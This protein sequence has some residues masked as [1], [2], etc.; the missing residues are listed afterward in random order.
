MCFLKEY[1][2]TYQRLSQTEHTDPYSVHEYLSGA[3]GE[4]VTVKLGASEDFIPTVMTDSIRYLLNV[5]KI[6][7]AELGLEWNMDE[8]MKRLGA[9][10]DLHEVDI[11]LQ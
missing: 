4:K 11:E 10:Q 9:L 7:S 3:E 8:D 6:C 1:G 5:R 2:L